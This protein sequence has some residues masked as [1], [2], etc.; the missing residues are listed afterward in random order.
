MYV[1]I[2]K[3]NLSINQSINQSDQCFYFRN[4]PERQESQGKLFETIRKQYSNY[5][6]IR[7]NAAPTVNDTDSIC[8]T[9]TNQLLQEF[10]LL[11]NDSLQLCITVVK[12]GKPISADMLVVILPLCHVACSQ[13]KV[14]H[15][16]C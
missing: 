11:R 6:S 14:L 12:Q 13:R 16:C 7:Y 15:I 10:Q 2:T 3:G 4:K 5:E 1:E 8:R 9:F